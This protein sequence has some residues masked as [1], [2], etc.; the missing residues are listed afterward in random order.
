MTKNLV[1]FCTKNH[2][3]R[4]SHLPICTATST[5]NAER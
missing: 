1:K 3:S 2:V 5:K 4:G